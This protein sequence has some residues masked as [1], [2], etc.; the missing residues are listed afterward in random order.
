MAYV[1]T[2][3]RQLAI[4]QGERDPDTGKVLQ[5]VLFLFY[6]EAEVHQAFGLRGVE[7]RFKELLEARHPRIR[8]DWK[9]IALQVEPTLHNLPKDDAT[10]EK[11]RQ[12]DFRKELGGLARWLLQN[13]PRES[14]QAADLVREHWMELEYLREILGNHVR[15]A[16]DGSSNP[17]EDG[18]LPW[19]FARSGNEIPPDAEEHA[20][21]FFEKGDL[22]R[23]E[24]IFKLLVEGFDRYA[25][26]HNY[27]GLIALKRGHL[28]E[29]IAQF[30]KTVEVGRNLFPRRYSRLHYWLELSTRP[31]VRGLVNLGWALIVAGRYEE[32]LSVSDRLE[33]EC[34]D[35]ITANSRRACISLNLGLW[36][37]A[38]DCAKR[39]IKVDPV[40]SFLLA[41]AH[42]E[43]K[44][45]PEALSAF[46]YGAL[47]H[48]GAVPILLGMEPQHSLT[49]DD[50]KDN[51]VVMDL[52]K[53]LSG[54]FRRQS[55]AAGAF[56]DRA[57]SHPR[58]RRLLTESRLLGRRWRQ[59]GQGSP[60][61]L[62]RRMQA[63]RSQDFARARALEL[64]KLGQSL[65]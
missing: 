59:G 41:F 49:I 4:V 3:G 39:A 12:A 16:Q 43:L 26:G 60:Q 5:R 19:R 36:D 24:S 2:A 42:A 57:A 35:Q 28:K 38:A 1:R 33:G 8:F 10:Q 22:D 15:L 6:S 7:D 29:A 64:S 37:K 23:A 47:H 18:P 52:R 30:Q 61:A 53:G 65:R 21:A 46:L 54:Y 34:G 40:E 27:L 56:L 14:A 9:K 32:A 13:D 31:F 45:G 20:A 51:D 55:M 25:E 44:N 63:M 62:L 50:Q 58:V 48:P 11:D 17:G